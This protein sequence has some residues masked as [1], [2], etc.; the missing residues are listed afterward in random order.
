MEDNDAQQDYM[1]GLCVQPMQEY[2][3]GDQLVG[4]CVVKMLIIGQHLNTRIV[5]IGI[6]FSSLYV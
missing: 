4:A 6:I 3:D 5:F 2:S 1:I